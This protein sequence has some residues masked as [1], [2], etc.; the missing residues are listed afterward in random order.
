MNQ[1]NDNENDNSSHSNQNDQLSNEDIQSSNHNNSIDM[2]D[3]QLNENIPQINQNNQQFN[4]NNPQLNSNFPP[5]ISNI[6][7]FNPHNSQINT[8][9]YYNNDFYNNNY[10]QINNNGYQPP[11]NF[12]PPQINNFPRHNDFFPQRNINQ[13]FN[14]YNN[15]NYNPQFNFNT[16]FRE[17]QNI[18]LQHNRRFHNNSIIDNEEGYIY[19]S[20]IYHFQNMN[21]RG[22][23]N[24][25]NRNI[26]HPPFPPLV[27]PY[28]GLRNNNPNYFFPQNINRPFP[29]MQ[30]LNPFNR[31]YANP[32]FFNINPPIN[33]EY[34]NF[35]LNRNNNNNQK[36]NDL[37][38]EVEVTE[39]ILKNLKI[40]ECSICLDEFSLEAKICYL[41]CF[42]YFHYHCIKKWT[43]K[44][45][46]CP[47]CN[48]LIKFE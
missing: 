40:K 47:I 4:Q 22:L 11:N 16:Q 44:S 33:P 7:L 6:P 5:I 34:D 12:I 27:P 20:D 31:P 24:L 10:S 8:N 14:N 26:S 42:H 2:E 29:F 3:Q 48:T 25:E 41:P 32:H 39:N 45:L 9:N 15:Y 23:Q 38:E 18:P 46:K 36:I 30:N 37:L 17:N 43:E 19:S 13:P 21:R 28:G 35:S 1:N